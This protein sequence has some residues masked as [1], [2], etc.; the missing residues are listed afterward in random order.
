[1]EISKTYRIGEVAKMLN[2]N[3]STLR[4]WETKF[5]EIDSFRTDKG[6]R[7]Y[8][9]EKVILLR[10]IQQLLHEHGMTIDGAKRVIES[11]INVDSENQSSVCAEPELAFMQMLAAELTALRQILSRSEL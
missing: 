5:P 8:T 2:V 3:P 11:N 6:Q 1:M 7:F 4:F 10:Q 9:E